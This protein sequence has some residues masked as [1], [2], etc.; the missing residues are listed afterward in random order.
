MSRRSSCG[1]ESCSS[2]DIYTRNRNPLLS[3]CEL[4]SRD[5]WIH[6]ATIAAAI[7]DRSTRRNMSN[8]SIDKFIHLLV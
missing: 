5:F 3:F 8:I 4:I 6:R 1:S 7:Y 2:S